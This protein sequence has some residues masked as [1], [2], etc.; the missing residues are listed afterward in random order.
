MSTGWYTVTWLLIMAAAL[1]AR[2]YIQRDYGVPTD[3]ARLRTYLR[4]TRATAR[5]WRAVRKSAG[6]KHHDR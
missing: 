6:R 4:D 1:T 3:F 5:Y 2:W